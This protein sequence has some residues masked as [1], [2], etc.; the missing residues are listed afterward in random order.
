MEPALLLAVFL[1]GDDAMLKVSRWCRLAA[2][3]AIILC[4][5][6]E[7]YGQ[8][9][10]TAFDVASIRPNTESGPQRLNLYHNSR[11]RI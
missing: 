6:I 1:C 4:P 2:A 8:G 7:M 10:G 9:D 3:A 5:A 11:R